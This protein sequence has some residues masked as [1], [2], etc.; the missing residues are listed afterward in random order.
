[1]PLKGEVRRSP[2][3]SALQLIARSGNLYTVLIRGERWIVKRRWSYAFSHRGAPA[4]LFE[5]GG[6]RGEI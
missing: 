6:G 1:M 5:R 2:E 3:Q 4:L